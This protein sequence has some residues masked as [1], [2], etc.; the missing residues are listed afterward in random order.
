MDRFQQFIDSM[1]ARSGEIAP[2]ILGAVLIFILGY[3]IAKL[4]Q[5]LTRN[6][7]NRYKIDERLD[8][9]NK[10][11]V[12]LASGI[13]KMIYYLVMVLVLLVVLDILG[14][15]GVLEPLQN[16]LNK[17]LEYIP[18]VIAAILIGIAGYM[19]AKIASEAVGFLASGLEDMGPKMGFKKGMS[20]GQLVKQIVFLFI[21]VPVLLI[22]LDALQ[23]T[24]ISEPASEMLTTMLAAIP[25]IIAAAIIVLVFYVAGRFIVNFIV[26]LLDNLGVETLPT[27]LGISGMVGNKS[28]PKLIGNV[29]FFFLMFFAVIS[30]VEKLELTR[31]SSILNDL[32]ELSGQ[33]FLGLIIMVLGNYIS[34]LVADYMRSSNQGALTSIVRFATLGLFLAIALRT[35]GIANDIVN[36]AFGLTLGAVAVAFALSFGLG[37]REAAGKHM[38]HLL[39]KWRNQN[40]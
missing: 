28:L 29:L 13:S 2:R 10:I 16:M 38:E 31:L 40:K 32:L 11:D 33:I 26:E 20:L 17:F 4:V 27:K 19:I 22:A 39:S 5:R 12:N 6:L 34:N 18:H 9:D 7:L 1:F 23:I 3:F 21:F 30:A 35:M 24:L 37:G 36:L 14:V 8:K 25:N 15:Q